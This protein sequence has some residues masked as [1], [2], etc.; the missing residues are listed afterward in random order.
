MEENKTKTHKT[1]FFLSKMV[2]QNKWNINIVTS[3]Y[4]GSQLAI[5]DVVMR[6]PKF[7]FQLKHKFINFKTT[8]T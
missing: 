4:L 7:L 2:A 5:H 1:S 6:S 3:V 8:T